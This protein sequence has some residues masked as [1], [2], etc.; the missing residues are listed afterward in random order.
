[1]GE[2]MGVAVTPQNSTHKC[3]VAESGPRL[4]LADLCLRKMTRPFPVVQ[5]DI[6]WRTLWSRP[7]HVRDE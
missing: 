7:G 2:Q 4:Q 6:V 1:M 5:A 3:V